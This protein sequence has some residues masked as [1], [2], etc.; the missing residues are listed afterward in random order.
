M[1][2]GFAIRPENSPTSEHATS[3]D[4]DCK[5]LGGM[6]GAFRDVSAWLTACPVPLSEAQRAAILAAVRAAVGDA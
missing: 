6:L 5:C 3:C 2:N 4:E 1:N